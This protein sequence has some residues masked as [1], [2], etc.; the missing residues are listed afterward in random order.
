MLLLNHSKIQ[1]MFKIFK[2]TRQLTHTYGHYKH[3]IGIYHAPSDQAGWKQT[4]DNK[5]LFVRS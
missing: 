3:C 2:N 1:S 4:Q 5:P